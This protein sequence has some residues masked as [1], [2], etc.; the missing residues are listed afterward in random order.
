MEDEDYTHRKN[1][2][3]RSNK[4]QA[5]SDS[6]HYRRSLPAFSSLDWFP[7]RVSEIAARSKFSISNA[8]NLTEADYAPGG[9]GRAILFEAE[10]FQGRMLYLAEWVA[11][12]L[13]LDLS[14]I[15]GL[16]QMRLGLDPRGG[17]LRRECRRVVVSGVRYLSFRRLRWRN[18]EGRRREGRGHRNRRLAPLEAGAREECMS[19]R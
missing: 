13:R 16:S 12:S 3:T 4:F 18:E 1:N 19:T 14:R 8:R 6:L 7:L 17:E 11:G 15:G 9:E 10:D 2:W 5:E